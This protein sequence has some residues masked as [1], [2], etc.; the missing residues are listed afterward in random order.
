MNQEIEALL[1]EVIDLAAKY[2]KLTGKPLGITGEV[3]EFYAAK[4]LN[5][6]LMGARSPG[7]DAIGSDSRK[8]QI[9]GRCLPDKFKTGQRIGSIRLEHQWDSV[10][11]VL[12]DEFFVVTE[13][14]EAD[15]SMV[16]AALLAPGSKSRNVRGALSVSKFKQISKK[17]WPV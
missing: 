17:V 15:R 10:I 3:A 14:W 16:E 8:I 11:L 12:M 5:L 7:Y 9:K 1:I 2:K 6:K 4:L 13:M